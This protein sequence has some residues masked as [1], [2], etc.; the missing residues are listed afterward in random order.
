MNYPMESTIFIS[1]YNIH[2]QT[3]ETISKVNKNLFLSDLTN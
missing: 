1:N 3:N 2:D